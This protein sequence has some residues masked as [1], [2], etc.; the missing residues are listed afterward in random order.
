MKDKPIVKVFDV[1]AAE[2]ALKHCPKIV[3]DYVSLLQG[4]L[5]HQKELTTSAMRK[6][7]ELAKK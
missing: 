5:E 3:R 7:R 4:N 2:E 6:I 1:R